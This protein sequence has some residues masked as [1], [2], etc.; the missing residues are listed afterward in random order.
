MALTEIQVER[1]VNYLLRHMIEDKVD[2]QRLDQVLKYVVLNPLPSRATY[3]AEE[4]SKE[5]AEKQ[6]HIAALKDQLSKLEGR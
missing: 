2:L 5:E 4:L 3:E 1:A 6:R